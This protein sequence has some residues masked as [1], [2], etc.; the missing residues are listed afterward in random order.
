MVGFQIIYWIMFVFSAIAT[1]IFIIATFGVL[2]DKDNK[3]G[4]YLLIPACLFSAFMFIAAKD[5]FQINSAILIWKISSGISILSSFGIAIWGRQTE[6]AHRIISL[7]CVSLIGGF[8]FYVNMEIEQPFNSESIVSVFKNDITIQSLLIASAV[9]FVILLIILIMNSITRRKRIKHELNYLRV[10]LESNRYED[11]DKSYFRDPYNNLL[12]EEF[13]LFT[14]KI[15]KHLSS[16]LHD[17]QRMLEEIKY[18]SDY[19]KLRPKDNDI[20]LSIE[21]SVIVTEISDIKRNI[22]ILMQQNSSKEFDNLDVVKELN[23]FISTP[24][25]SVISNLEIIRSKLG[26]K[27]YDVHENLDRIKSSIDL[28]KCVI[29]TYREVAILST[30]TDTI[31]GSLSDI[32]RN[33]LEIFRESHN[34]KNLIIEININDTVD[35]FSNHYLISILMPLLENAVVASPKDSTIKLY[36]PND[37]E[38]IIQNKCTPP[39]NIRDLNTQGYSS[40]DGHKGT[41]LMIVRHLLGIKKQ[42]ALSIVIE[43]NDVIQTVKLNR[44]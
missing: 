4:S 40:K 17:M 22:S 35:G 23:H 11:A 12:K 24:F 21:N 25:S 10:K 18:R 29:A 28:C 6:K 34:K 38:F 5:I 14:R 26:K 31:I 7:I 39:P 2:A 43:K 20:L 36:Q 9:L 15:D 13:S 27:V 33:T 3:G 8:P 1:L 32:V 16:T 19:E 30:S 41:G 44:M 37:L 42:G